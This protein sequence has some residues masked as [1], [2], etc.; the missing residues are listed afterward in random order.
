MKLNCKLQRLV[1]LHNKAALARA[2]GIT[3][4]RFRFILRGKVD[5]SR[6]ELIN[7]AKAMH[8]DIG[9]LADDARDWPPIF[10]RDPLPEPVAA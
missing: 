4:D 1:A 3:S 8:V 10:T 7:L 5:P 6:T 9:W 2:T